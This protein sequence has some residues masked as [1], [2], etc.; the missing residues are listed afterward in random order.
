MAA[1]QF[2]GIGRHAGRQVDR[3]DRDVRGIEIR[4]HRLIETAQRVVQ[5]GA[6]D[7]IDD[8][9]VRGHFRDMQLPCAFVRNL[10]D[11]E[12]EPSENLEIDARVARHVRRRADEE[13]GDV[14][15]ALVQR[16]DHHE[17]VAAVVALAAHHRDAAFGEIGIE[18]LDRRDGLAA[19]VLHEHERR[20]T[21]LLDRPSIGFAHLLCVENPHRSGLPRV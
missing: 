12:T 7:R 2:A 19:G 14:V 21:D 13:R 15:A 16:A 3:D 10:D 20:Q 11:I 8:E 9:V 1:N 5:A 18:R 4:D 17:A 6:D